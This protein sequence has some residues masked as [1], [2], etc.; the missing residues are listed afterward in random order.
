M[1]DIGWAVSVF[2][3]SIWLLSLLNVVGVSPFSLQQILLPEV[4]IPLSY[5]LLAFV[6]LWS[7]IGLFYYRESLFVSLLLMAIT[8]IVVL[9]H[10][11]GALYGIASPA[12]GFTVTQKVS[13][14]TETEAQQR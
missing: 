5:T 6:Y 3:P 8:P 10:S 9:I 13:R 7:L 4:Y 11:I 1:R 2:A 14:A 12:T